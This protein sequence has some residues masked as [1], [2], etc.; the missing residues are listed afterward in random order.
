MTVVDN[1]NHIRHL[2]PYRMVYDDNEEDDNYKLRRY[3]VG[4]IMYP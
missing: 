2:Y 1:F 4:I 3:F